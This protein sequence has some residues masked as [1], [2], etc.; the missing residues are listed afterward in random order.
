MSKCDMCE[1]AVQIMSGGRVYCE[2]MPEEGGDAD[3]P[4]E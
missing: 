4:C 3:D 1:R 2:N